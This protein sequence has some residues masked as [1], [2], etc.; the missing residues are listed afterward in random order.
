MTNAQELRDNF[1]QLYEAMANSADVSKMKHFG[2]GFKMMFG[3]IANSDT[4]LAIATLEYLAAMEYNNY[5]TAEEAAAIASRFINDDTTVTGSNT[6]SNGA[7][8]SIDTA[9]SFLTSRGIPLE[10]K[11]FYNWPA[12]WLTMNMEYSDY[13]DA[14][15]ELMGDK[16]GEKIAT[17]CYKMA[18]KKLKDRDRPHFIREYFELDD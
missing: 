2:K 4:K 10:E 15:V 14:L 17:A 3:K 13:A 9:K 12:L 6:P 1:E 16:N 11:P 8:W 18:I 5:V 7:H